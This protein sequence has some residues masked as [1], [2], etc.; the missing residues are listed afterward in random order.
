[1]FLRILLLSFYIV[2]SLSAQAV[3]RTR[4]ASQAENI[5]P[6]LNGQFVPN[7]TLKTDF[8]KPINLQQ[9]VESKPSVL[10]FYRGGWCPFCSRQLS[11]L[12]E[13]QQQIIDLG[14]QIIAISP[15]SP[16]R[17]QQQK[18]DD[19][20]QLVR[21]SDT[22]FKAIRAFG[23]AYE[24]EESM[25]TTLQ[26]RN[27]AEV[28]R[29]EGKGVLPVPAVFVTNTAG[30]ITFQYVNPNYRERIDPKLLFTAARI[31]R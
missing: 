16:E 1:M 4:V 22:E 14:Y 2:A 7:V 8:G 20:F 31:A 10:I 5:N 9:L 6:L 13:V 27:K 29:I 15:D 25:V 11:G 19:N 12:M 28:V 26:Q 23:L 24:L 17:M 21:L 30:L 3:D 18:F